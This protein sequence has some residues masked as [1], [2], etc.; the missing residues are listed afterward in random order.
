MGMKTE[1]PFSVLQ[2]RRPVSRETENVK[3]NNIYYSGFP[4][5]VCSSSH[6]HTLAWHIKIQAIQQVGTQSVDDRA[7]SFKKGPLIRWLAP[8]K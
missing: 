1:I 3:E 2:I 5:L 8:T 6:S 7:G 4:R